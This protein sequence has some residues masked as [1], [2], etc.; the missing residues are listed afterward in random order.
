MWDPQHLTA[1]QA[2]TA[3]YGVSFTL[4]FMVDIRLM[5]SEALASSTLCFFQKMEVA[6]ASV[7]SV[8]VYT[9]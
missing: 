1:L 7:M 3:C 2:S 9:S 8:K 5:F 4:I 6:R